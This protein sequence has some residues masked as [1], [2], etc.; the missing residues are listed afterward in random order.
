MSAASGRLKIALP[1]IDGD[2]ER[3]IGGLAPEL[4]R[5]EDDRVDLLRFSPRPCALVSGKT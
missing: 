3:R 2:G 4:G 1:R 5:G